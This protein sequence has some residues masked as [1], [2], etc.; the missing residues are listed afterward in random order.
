MDLSLASVFVAGLL[1]FLSPCVLPLAPIYL[2]VLAGDAEGGNR[3]RTLV[4]TIIFALGFTLVF[5][6]MGLT[7][8]AIGQVLARNK[9][10]FQQLGGI[11]ILLLG[12]RFLGWL[13]IP[14]LSSLSGTSGLSRWRTRFHFLNVFILG[15]LFAFAWSPCIGSV[16]GAVLTWTSLSTT[17]PVLGMLYLATYG[18]GFAVPL[19]LV[20]AI[21]GPALSALKRAKRFIPVFERVTGGLLIVFGLALATDQV[22]LLDRLMAHP[23]PT[24]EAAPA[25]ASAPLDPFKTEQCAPGNETGAQCNAAPAQEVPRMIKFYSPT[26]PVCLSMVPT[27]NLL[28]QECRA[29]AVAFESVDIST[30]EGKTLARKYGVTGIPVFV[31]EDP[32]GK[33]VAR[34][35]G[36]Q[37]LDALEQAMT[38][39][40]GEKCPAYREIPALGTD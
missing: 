39:L 36:R 6:L 8:T 7:A 33:E 20:A 25:E 17:D 12:L 3:F 21:A 27:I 22:G 9:L 2:G 37:T 13:N 11:L 29:K 19:L 40:I 26:C 10:L 18:A 38:V 1:T 32:S 30:A 5:A 4:S 34:L 24:A 14:F 35:V 28:R 31:F 15:V 16:L 23:T